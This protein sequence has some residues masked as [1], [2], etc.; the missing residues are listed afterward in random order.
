MKYAIISDIH[1]NLEALTKALEIIDRHAVD[2]I[3]CLGDI[4]GYGA[5]P[6]DCTALVQERCSIVVLGNHDAAVFNAA[7]AADFNLLAKNAIAWTRKTLKEEHRQYLASL[8][9]THQKES[10]HFVHASPLSP[11]SFDYIL[12]SH[13]AAD[14]FHCFDEKLCFIGHTHVPALFARGG[15]AKSINCVEQFIVNVGSIGQ[16][17]DGNPMLAFGIFDSATWE[18]QLIRSDYNAQRA[19]EKIID[20]GLPQELGFRLLYGM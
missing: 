1:A 17:R 6:N 10:L 11:E 3:V 18:Y 16:P 15:K 13:D 12:N 2:E 20:A 7:V 9:Y 8:P 19:S 14:A 5:D 4:V